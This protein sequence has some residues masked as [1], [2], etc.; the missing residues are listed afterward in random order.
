MFEKDLEEDIYNS[1][2][3]NVE[4]LTRSFTCKGSSRPLVLAIDL[5]ILSVH[6]RKGIASSRIG[7][8]LTRGEGEQSL[9][10]TCKGNEAE[11]SLQI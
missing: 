8:P 9:A 7:H 5:T 2:A 1:Q 11:D 3:L 10:M 4:N 6:I